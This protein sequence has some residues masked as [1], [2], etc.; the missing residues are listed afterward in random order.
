M[1]IAPAVFFLETNRFC[2]PLFW[3]QETLKPLEEY[4]AEKEIGVAPNEGHDVNSDLEEEDE[5]EDEEDEEDE[6]NRTHQHDGHTFEEALAGDIK[7]IRDLAYGRPQSLSSL[8]V[9]VCHQILS[10]A[11]QVLCLI[12]KYM[13]VSRKLG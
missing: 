10:F 5:G 7:L 13:V 3:R 1:H 12:S 8:E 6:D 9:S 4:G 11:L 2:E